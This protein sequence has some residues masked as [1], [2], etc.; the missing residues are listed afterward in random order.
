MQQVE[1]SEI[2]NDVH[3]IVEFLDVDQ[4]NYFENKTFEEILIDI[5]FEILSNNDADTRILIIKSSVLFYKKIFDKSI[6][7]SKLDFVING[8]ITNDSAVFYILV[9]NKNSPYRYIDCNYPADHRLKKFN[10]VSD[11]LT[12]IVDM[13]FD[14]AT[15]KI[16]PG[17]IGST[18]TIV[19]TRFASQ[20]MNFNPNNWNI[21]DNIENSI[22]EK[23]IISIKNAIIPYY[24]IMF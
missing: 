13:D 15:V 16:K 7:F 10:L 9:K 1:V 18:N 19:F 22:L 20:F 6:E 4:Y 24:S 11:N 17:T 3:S 14:I 12:I 2:K 5:I 23:K 21:V 8:Y